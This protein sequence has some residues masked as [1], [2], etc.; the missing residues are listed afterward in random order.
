MLRKN[1]FYLGTLAGLGA[2]VAGWLVFWLLGLLLDKLTGI[3]PYLQ[4]WQIY[5]LGL[6]PPVVLMRY[7]FI[8]RKLDATAKGVLTVVVVLGL[9]YFI[10]LKIKGYLI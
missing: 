1:N 5:L 10:Y 7:F 6:I 4:R 3:E 8:N 2:A 9:G